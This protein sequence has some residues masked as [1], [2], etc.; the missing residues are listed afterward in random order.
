MV[1]M[2]AL[3]FFH[4]CKHCEMMRGCIQVSTSIL[5]NLHGYC[6]IKPSQ[7]H[8][9]LRL[10]VLWMSGILT[11]GD[12]YIWTT[13]HKKT[14]DMCRNPSFPVFSVSDCFCVFLKVFGFLNVFE[15]FA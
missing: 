2:P 7:G 3:E 15:V 10:Y 5:L 6:R 4:S 8:I 9:Q 12:L 1:S 14:I 13:N 11:Y